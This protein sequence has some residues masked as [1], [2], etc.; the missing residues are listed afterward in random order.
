VHYR[1]GIIVQEAAIPALMN[2]QN[3]YVVIATASAS[4]TG[5]MFVTITLVAGIQQ[6]ATSDAV[7][8]FSSPSVVHFCLALFVA[9]L[10]LVPWPALWIAGIVLGL[11]GLGGVGYVLIV[12]RRMNRQTNYIP[13]LEDWLCHVVLPLVGY[14][15]LVGAGIV[16]PDNATA[17]MFVVA[18]VTLLLLF[19]GI[20][21]AWDIVLYL[22]I[23]M[24]RSDKQG[25][26]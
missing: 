19:I 10:L 18:A 25:Q 12:L 2:W 1:K 6:R 16:L 23:E 17:A 26:D 20:H 9:A 22:A 11:V 21:N 7:G 13:V 14:I 24:N 15:A 3:F 4:L 8:A 5:L